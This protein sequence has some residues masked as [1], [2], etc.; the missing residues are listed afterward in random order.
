M[1]KADLACKNFSNGLNCAQSIL[2][3]YAP[4]FS[5]EH[6]LVLKIAVPF[7]GGICRQGETC[8]AVSA[9]LMVIGLKA[10]DKNANIN[11][12]KMHIYEISQKFI[13]EFKSINNS[14]LCKELLGFDF[15]KPEEASIIKDKKITANLCPKFI[16]DVCMILEKINL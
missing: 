12:A 13:A 5:L 11:D 14:S 16:R 1:N 10:Y 3:A 7:G 9:S 15:S 6:E 8:G 2:C 4:E